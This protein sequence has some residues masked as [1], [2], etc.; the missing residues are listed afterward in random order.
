MPN[1]L[2]EPEFMAEMFEADSEE[3]SAVNPA[4]ETALHDAAYALQD[5][6]KPEAVI[7]DF[8]LRKSVNVLVGESGD[9][10]SWILLDCAIVTA[11]GRPFLGFQTKPCRAGYFDQDMGDDFFTERVG[12]VLRGEGGSNTTPF[13]YKSM[14]NLNLSEPTHAKL[15]QTWIEA[16][17]LEIVFLDA[18]IDFLGIVEENSAT[19]INPIFANLRNIADKT[20]V[21]FIIAHHLNRA[22]AYRGSSAIKGKVDTMFELSRQADSNCF[23][24][25]TSK[26]RHGKHLT[27][28]GVMHWEEDKFYLTKV[29]IAPTLHLTKAQRFALDYFD[30]K[31]GCL[32]GLVDCAGGLYATT[33][34]KTATADLVLRKLL[35]RKNAGG[36]GTEA[37]YGKNGKVHEDENE[38]QDE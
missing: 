23:T 15:L 34:L 19:E 18:L 3:T 30:D 37:I 24:V 16:Y 17:Q 31:D 7:G 13:Y 26:V 27:F 32:S 10:K 5:H 28:S 20:G 14:P 29:I 11:E 12:Q 9:G 22:G 38:Y 8:I 36:K 2:T 6:P 33:T 21:A 1:M 4:T 35:M 25:K